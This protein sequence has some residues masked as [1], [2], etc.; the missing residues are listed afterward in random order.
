MAHPLNLTLCDRST[1][2]FRYRH[3]R[4]SSVFPIIGVGGIDRRA[5]DQVGRYS[6]LIFA[7]PG[8]VKEL[9]GRER[10]RG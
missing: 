9:R 5:A 3:Q 6:G 10:E 1:D 7:G 8:R 4:L 2:E